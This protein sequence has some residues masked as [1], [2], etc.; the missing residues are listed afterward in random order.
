M[1][2]S[3]EAS[4]GKS[5]GTSNWNRNRNWKANQTINEKNPQQLVISK[6]NQNLG[7]REKETNSQANS[8]QNNHMS[9]PRKPKHDHLAKRR[10]H[11]HTTS[12]VDIKCTMM[13]HTLTI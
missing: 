4:D 11:N 6:R 10:K 1:P 8:S 9:N 2:P 12:G 5:Q 7:K 3:L 13:A